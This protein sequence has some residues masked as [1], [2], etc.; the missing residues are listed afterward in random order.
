MLIILVLVLHQP[1]QAV[2]TSDLRFLDD[3]IYHPPQIQNPALNK[4]VN[5][6]FKDTKLSYILLLLSKVGEFNVVLPEQ[7]DRDI[8]ITLSQ[9]RVI[10]SIEDICK[11]TGL[12]Y[13]FKSNSLLITKP[14][15]QGISFISVPVVHNSAEKIVESLNNILFKQLAQVQ[16]E[17]L[18]KP[19]AAVDSSNNSVIVVA[20]PEQL[21]L[22]KSFILELDS[23][24]QVRIFTPSYLGFLDARK[25]SSIHFSEKSS[26]KLKRF[27]QNSFLLKG[28]RDEVKKAL[29]ILK[30]YDTAPK[31]VDLTIKTYGILTDQSSEFTKKNN[32]IDYL[33]L[34]K[35][36][37]LAFNDNLKF[38]L[39][40]L[41]VLD[42]QVIQLNRNQEFDYNDIKIKARTNMIESDKIMITAFDDTLAALDFKNEMACKFIGPDQLK[43]YKKLT[44]FTK[45][46]YSLLLICL[47]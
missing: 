35:I 41:T 40:L 1:A 5:F 32:L 29:E 21:A 38:P 13:E 37:R 28:S 23:P 8:S 3:A 46:D 36:D 27:E 17:T 33:K 25:L 34:Q 31:P 45:R 39:N 14:T 24:P 26:F 30:A 16:N 2:F 44:K 4:K 11:L 7:Y 18:S 43:I 10:D 6:S 12:T 15:I 20:H 22:A 47:E 42:T 19:H 9:E